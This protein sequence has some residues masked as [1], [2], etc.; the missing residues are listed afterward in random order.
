MRL[1][2]RP[3]RTDEGKVVGVCY[4]DLNNAGDSVCLFLRYYKLP[5]FGT[6][7]SAG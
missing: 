3:R 6:T 7:G 4:A 1:S 5:A 2:E